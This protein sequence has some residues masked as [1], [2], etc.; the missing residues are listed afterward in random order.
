MT[1]RDRPPVRWGVLG[2]A[3]IGLKKV[4]PAMQAV[5]HCDV[6]AIASRDADR[7]RRAAADLGI[8]RAHGSYEALLADPAVEAIYNPLPNHLHVPWSIRAAN[9]GKHVLCEKP[10]G[11]KAAEARQLLEVRDRTGVIMA[12]AFMIRTHPQWL[13]V[14][15]RVRQGALGELRLVA[16]QFSYFNDDPSDIRNQRELGG[17]ALM[18]IGC[19][20]VHASRW[21]FDAEPRRV[22]ARVHRDPDF[23]TDILTSGILDF[24]TGRGTFTCGTQLVPY[25]RVQVLG[26]RGRIE[27]EIP[28]NAPPEHTCRIRIDDGR[29]PRGTG[30]RELT[31]E[32]VDQ[33]G[34]Q[35]VAFA[36]AVRGA[37]RVPVPLEDAV[38]NM[39]VIDALFRSEKSAD[40]ETP[41]G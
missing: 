39:A 16:C 29:D 2:T 21:L 33:Y 5:D 19:Y 8:E 32:P 12:E 18:D 4:I 30:V 41:G 28:F 10:V 7:A 14:R 35:G 3:D 15:D 6:V 9:A 36:R 1:P 27:V 23:D 11:L 25:Q 20:A 31:F 38:G 17:G 34:T 13:E 37:G 40:W 22:L 24:G 26:T